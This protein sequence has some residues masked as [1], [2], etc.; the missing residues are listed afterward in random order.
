M[1]TFKYAVVIRGEIEAKNKENANMHVIMGTTLSL[2]LM[3]SPHEI[4]INIDD[5]AESV[6]GKISDIQP[7]ERSEDG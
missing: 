1:P 2:R 5:M 3:S 7:V 4:G 6:N